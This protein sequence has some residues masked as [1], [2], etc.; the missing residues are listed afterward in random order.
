MNSAGP[1]Q[2]CEGSKSRVLDVPGLPGCSIESDSTRVVENA[3][4]CWEL[5]EVCTSVV[6]LVKRERT[7]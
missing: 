4:L 6:L 2:S 7:K 5:A 1:E 3:V